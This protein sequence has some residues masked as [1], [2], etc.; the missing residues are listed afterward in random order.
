MA[1]PTTRTTCAVDVE[2]KTR[3]PRMFYRAARWYSK[4]GTFHLHFNICAVHFFQIIF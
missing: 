1:P 3:P 4:Q 2:R